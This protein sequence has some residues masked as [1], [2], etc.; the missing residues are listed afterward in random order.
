MSISDISTERSHV[1]AHR[2]K[3]QQNRVLFNANSIVYVVIIYR[4]RPMQNAKQAVN[5]QHD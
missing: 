1:P 2:N 5:W 3:T 4:Y